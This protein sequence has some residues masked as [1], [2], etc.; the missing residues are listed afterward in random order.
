M[1]NQVKNIQTSYTYHPEKTRGTA[2][3]G[4]LV[5]KYSFSFAGYYNPERINFGK[6]RVLN[7][8][9]IAPSRGFSTHPHENMEIISIVLQGALGHEDDMGNQSTINAGE[10]QI[11]SAG[12]GVMHSEVNVSKNEVTNLLQIWVFPKEYNITPRYDQKKFEEGDRV[13]QW[14]IIVSPKHEEA[15][16]INQDAYF[17][18]T[19]LESGN[20]LAYNLHKPDN[21]VYLFLIEGSVKVDSQIHLQKRDGLG[22]HNT[23]SIDLHANETS[24][25]LAM[26]V[27]MF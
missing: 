18:L 4:W 22:V 7:D 12:S 23:Q 14:Q 10:V 9:L 13:N 3:F 19:K 27:P 8:D 15:L 6:L 24:F 1:E 25:L 5:A 2:N 21:G 26:E 20:K 11:M 16:W 17:S